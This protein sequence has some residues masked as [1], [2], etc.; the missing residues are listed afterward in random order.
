M[1]ELFGA[2]LISGPRP[3]QRRGQKVDVMD[4]AKRSNSVR[5]SRLT[6]PSTPRG[7]ETRKRVLSA[8]VKLIAKY[9]YNA[10]NVQL[11]CEA[12]K[13][14]R[15]SVLHQ[16]PTRLDLM[17]A[18]LDYAHEG[19]IEKLSQRLDEA[20]K[21]MERLQAFFD[22]IWASVSE[23]S[24]A[25]VVSEIQD[26]AHWDVDLAALIAPASE[27]TLKRI[28]QELRAIARDAGIKDLGSLDAS[29]LLVIAATRG[30][31]IGF[32]VNRQKDALAA[33][34]ANLRTYWFTAI[35]MSR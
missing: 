28:S 9:G 23:D 31:A 7:M 20:A 26:A 1:M 19:L 16:F 15:G 18:V 27:K 14:A 24:M 30:L 4:H 33:A 8:A 5:V 17:M 29:L 32:R 3:S 35:K 25:T 21:P 34:L 10:T 13:V 2:M 22:A 11:I 12:S 6:Q